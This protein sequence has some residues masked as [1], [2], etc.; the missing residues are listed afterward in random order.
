[1]GFETVQRF[2]LHGHPRAIALDAQGVGHPISPKGRGHAYTPYAEITHVAS[3]ART[4]WIAARNSSYPLSRNAF[5]DPQAP[6]ELV[7]SLLTR[8]GELPDGAERLARMA[9]ID[10]RARR[11]HRP[12]ATWALVALCLAVFGLQLAFGDVVSAVGSFIPILVL[13]GDLWRVVTGNLLHGAPTFPMHLVLNLLGLVVLGSLVERPLGGGR[14]TLVMAVSGLAAM[15]AS[16]AAGYAE[17]VGVSGVVFGL[18]GSALW[19]ELRCAEELPAWLRIPRRAFVVL[20]LV[21]GVLMILLPFIAGAAHFGGFAAGFLA[22]GALT[23]RR[24]PVGGETPALR[25]A[26]AGVALGVAVAVGS[27]AAEF[28][29]EGSFV[30]RHAERLAAIPTVSPF[31]LNNAAWIIA[32]SPDSSREDFEAALQLAER[33]VLETNRAFPSLLDTL[34]EIQFQLGW[35]DQALATIDEAIAGAPGEPYYREQRKRFA[36]E[37]DADDRPEEPTPWMP[38]SREPPPE[39]EPEGEPGVTV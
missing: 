2:D 5:L 6:D 26:T 8:I 37:R 18:A 25:A 10:E 16:A 9:E 1:M 39:A 29:G 22:T 19:L 38:R 27:A 11:W 35:S 14:T 12:R 32:I 21:N 4:V 36:G 23:G 17:V 20:L 28:T 30:A 31:D 34:A 7:R 33:A 13:D 15:A 3:S 24:L